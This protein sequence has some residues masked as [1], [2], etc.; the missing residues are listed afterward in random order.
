M[1]T[2]DSVQGRTHDYGNAFEEIAKHL[3]LGRGLGTW[4]APKHQVF[5]NQYLLSLVEVG[6]LGMVA[7]MGIFSLA[8]MLPCGPAS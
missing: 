6:V 5:D 3:W 7:F 4:Y 8:S 2:D 1:G